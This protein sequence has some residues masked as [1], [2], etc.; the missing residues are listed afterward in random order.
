[1]AFSNSQSFSVERDTN[2][3]SIVGSTLTT[4]PN[5]MVLPAVQPSGSIIYCNGVM[6]YSNGLSWL[7]LSP[8]PIELAHT[9]AVNQ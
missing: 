8:L 3:T 4:V 2:S 6:Y 1:M 9:R 7:Y 5:Y